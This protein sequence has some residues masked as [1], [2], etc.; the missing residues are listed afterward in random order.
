MLIQNDTNGLN[1]KGYFG[2]TYAIVFPFL[3]GYKIQLCVI[4]FKTQV[5]SHLLILFRQHFDIIFKPN[6]LYNLHDIKTI[7]HQKEIR[8]QVGADSALC[9]HF[10]NV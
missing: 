2:Q 5:Y 3:T 4:F 8:K 1:R 10:R 6:S 7:F 9:P